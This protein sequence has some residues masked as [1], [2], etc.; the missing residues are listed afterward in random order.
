MILCRNR[1]YVHPKVKAQF[2]AEDVNVVIAKA[3]Q[4]GLTLKCVAIPAPPPK[5]SATPGFYSGRRFL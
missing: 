4:D 1:R 3:E 5:P 2:T